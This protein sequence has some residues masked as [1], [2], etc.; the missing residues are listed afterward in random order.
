MK[1]AVLIPLMLAALL[2]AEGC[3][4]GKSRTGSQAVR[5]TDETR[6]PMT[7]VKDQG[8]SG[9]C[10]IYAMLATI[11]TDRI[12]MGDS[13]SLSPDYAARTLLEDEARRCFLSRGRHKITMRG[14]ATGVFSLMER[15]GMTPFDSYHSYSAVNYRALARRT[16]LACRSA[17]TLGG[18]ERRVSQ[19]L[20]DC[21]S[22]L[23]RRVFMLGAEY[24]AEEFARSVAMERDYEALTSFTHHPFGSRFAIETPDNSFGDKYLNVSIDSLVER[25]RQ[26]LRAGRAVC[27]EGDT[28]EEGFSFGRGIADVR[29]GQ[30][31][32][33]ELRQRHFD[34]LR[35]TDD[36][37]MAI[38]GTARDRRGRRFFIMKD[39]HGTGNPYGGMMYVSEDY[40]RLKTVAIVAHR[41]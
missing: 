8:R 35:T 34:T 39:S 14:M 27:W 11:E 13:V 16:E 40:V 22:A 15:H 28:S 1:N 3:R 7:P 38:I 17:K 32:T 29:P 37:C 36:H 10:W 2:A 21:I 30:P 12:A 33:Q 19:I 4:E 23:P 20:D 25:I 31:V 24:T 41:L 18:A 9:L 6:L 26:S 5:F